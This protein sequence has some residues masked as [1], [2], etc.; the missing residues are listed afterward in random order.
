MYNGF[1]LKLGTT[2]P[3][4]DWVTRGEEILEE[5]WPTASRTLDEFINVG[6]LDGDAIKEKWFR[7]TNAHVF[8]S[9]SHKDKNKAVGLAGFLHDE[10]GL[11]PFVDSLIWGDSRDLQRRIDR[12]CCWDTNEKKHFNYLQRNYA[13][14]HV[15][16]MLATSLTA[17]MDS[18][19]ALIFLDTPKSISIEDAKKPEQGKVATESPWIYH[20]LMTSSV[21]RRKVDP[22]RFKDADG[23]MVVAMQIALEDA[24]RARFGYRPPVEHLMELTDSAL[25]LC[26]RENL[27]VFA[28][29][30][31]LYDILKE[32]N[33]KPLRRLTN[34]TRSRGRLAKYFRDI[35]S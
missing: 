3:Y 9:H 26:R 22:R 5:R 23:H 24:N 20:E 32:N 11:L 27:K 29:L 4:S 30:D 10:L 17:A 33:S 19:E 7:K 18:C 15:N 35:E 8:I 12:E 28:A 1:K 14:S 31:F 16:M 21:L 25:R 34:T 6:V 13:T 2:N